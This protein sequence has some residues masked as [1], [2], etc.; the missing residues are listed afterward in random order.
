MKRV[1]IECDDTNREAKVAEAVD[2][3]D[4][5][6]IFKGWPLMIGEDSDVDFI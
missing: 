1:E 2:T 5:Q 4:I 3:E 6:Y